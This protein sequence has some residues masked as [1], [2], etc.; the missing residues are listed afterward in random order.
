MVASSSDKLPIKKRDQLV[1]HPLVGVKHD[2]AMFKK[3]F[4]DYNLDHILSSRDCK[5]LLSKSYI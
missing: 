4:K 1:A 5:T 3:R 2:I